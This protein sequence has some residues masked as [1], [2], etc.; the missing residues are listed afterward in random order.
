MQKNQKRKGND[1]ERRIYSCIIGFSPSEKRKVETPPGLEEGRRTMNSTNWPR[2][3]CHRV[4][5][6]KVLLSS[7]YYQKGAF[8]IMLSPKRYTFVSRLIFNVLLSSPSRYFCHHS[9]HSQDTFLSPLQYF[10]HITVVN[11]T[12]CLMSLSPPSSPNWSLYNC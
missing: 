2:Y 5:T 6:K 1:H 10:C 12:P 11:V 3:F 9:Y 4:I 7:C 8:V